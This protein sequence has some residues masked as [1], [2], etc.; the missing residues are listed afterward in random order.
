MLA[1]DLAV[2]IFVRMETMNL[3]AW[4]GL[5]GLI[6]ALGIAMKEMLNAKDW[7]YTIDTFYLEL[8]KR[9]EDEHKR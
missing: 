1:I 7:V 4:G 5:A 2:I 3:I 6:L 9:F 8:T